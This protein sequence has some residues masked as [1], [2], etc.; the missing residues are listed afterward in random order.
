MK[1]YAMNYADDKFRQ[2][3]VLNT[4]TA[5]K[6]GKV[7]EVIEATPAYIDNEFRKKYEKLL[8]NPVGGGLWLWKPYSIYKGLLSINEG[9]YLFY[10]DS[11][12]VYINRVDYL[13]RTA[14]REKQPIM[15]FE[16]PLNCR[17][18]TKRET[19]MAMKVEDHDENQILANFIL[20][21][22]CTE[23]I[24][25]IK[26][27][28]QFACMEVNLSPDKI[29]KDISEWEDFIEHREDQ[30]ILTLLTIK[31]GIQPFRDPSDYGK[32]P[33]QYAFPNR[34]YNPKK[35]NNSDYPI[36]VLSYRRGNSRKYKGKFLLKVFLQKIGI[37]TEKRILQ[38][39]GIK[40]EST[41][42]TLIYDPYY[43]GHHSEY[44]NTQIHI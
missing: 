14:E 17:Q 28:L 29:N 31:K 20:L 13:V 26:E 6:Y 38:Q 34:I 39:R 36:I 3:Q 8:N 27:W 11:G 42:Q 21:K 19:Y 16:L 33:F 25:F 30:S 5:Y 10:C 12:S 37:Y 41:K 4:K 44:V 15:V 22:K 40:M 2:T 1:I 43:T 18:Y 35:Y 9:D 7:D 32:F 24:S 23:S